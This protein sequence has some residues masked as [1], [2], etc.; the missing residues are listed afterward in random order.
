MCNL[1]FKLRIEQ[2]LTGASAGCQ[3]ELG[4]HFPPLLQPRGQVHDKIG[5]LQVLDPDNTIL[6]TQQELV[7][8]LLSHLSLFFRTDSTEDKK[9]E[10][11][12]QVQCPGFLKGQKTHLA[13]WDWSV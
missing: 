2:I 5:V 9:N 10:K 12:G 11:M 8:W 4:N 3:C 13:A 6:S 7:A 1:F